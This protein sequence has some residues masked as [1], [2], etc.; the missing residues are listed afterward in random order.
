MAKVNGGNGFK[1]TEV[2]DIPQE[3][4][5]VSL[6]SIVKEGK[7]TLNP[8]NFPDELFDY[9]SIPDFQTTGLPGQELGKKILSQ[10]LLVEKG[11]V[12]FGKLNPRVT[13][14]WEVAS[15]SPRRKIASTEFIPLVPLPDKTITRY[16]Y[17]LAF[18]D[19]VLPRARELVSGS[20]PSRQR[21]DTR[22]FL[23]MPIPLPPLPEQREIAH[24]LSTIQRAIAAQEAVIAAA[25]EVKRSLMHRLFTYGPY[26]DPL[27]T[28]ETEIGE[29][30]EHWELSTIGELCELGGGTVQ[31][32][33]FGSQ[34][35]ASDYVPD[36][37]PA[38]MPQ[39]IVDSRIVE[40]NIARVSVEDHRRLSR[41]HLRA[42]DIVYA[43]RGDI[44]R[45]ALVTQAQDGWLCGTGSFFIRIGE[46]G[47]KPLYLHYYLGRPEV[48]ARILSQAIGTTLLNLNTTIIK[49]VPVVYSAV[50]EQEQI[51]HILDTADR[52]IF[53]E[54]NRKAALQALFKS[55]LHELMTG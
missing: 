37:I 5:V 17:F 18:S 43:R 34:L 32:G 15:D 30:P 53:V 27:P 47:I 22:A 51:A 49:P 11:T 46:S 12:L 4:D 48:S 20:T 28:K 13:K 23:Q 24:V 39:D 36:G 2:G 19:Y 42:G 25:R 55:M 44:G 29:V 16:L 52:K 7:E 50:E 38:V 10:K 6:S 9:Y 33:P 31:T 41:Y 14:V 40:T 21:V 26:A 35:H 54:E 45:R 1:E 8:M 3:W